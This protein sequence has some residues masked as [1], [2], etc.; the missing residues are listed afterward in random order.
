MSPAKK[1]AEPQSDERPKRLIRFSV[2]G[3]ECEID[4]ND[5]EWGEMEEVEDYFNE[6]I[7]DV[8][9][10]T[11]KAHMFLGYLARRRVDPKWTLEKTRKLRASQIVELD[12]DPTSAGSES[13]DSGTQPSSK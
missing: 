7:N 13:G 3:T 4:L 11:A 8:D 2:D 12:P 1:Q 10:A 6:S 5:L 9:L